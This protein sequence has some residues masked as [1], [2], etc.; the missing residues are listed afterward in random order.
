MTETGGSGL[1]GNSEGVP[2]AR[3]YPGHR[4]RSGPVPRIVELDA[5]R[6]LAACVVAIHHVFVVFHDEIRS[7]VSGF[8]YSL[9][10]VVQAQNQAAVLLFF[11]LSGYAIGLATRTQPPV[12]KADCLHY[13]SRRAQRLLPLY[14]ISLAWTASLGNVYGHSNSSFGL[15]TLF[16]NALF[17][18]TSE[19]AKGAWFSPYGLNGPYWSLS[20]EIFFYLL[21]PVALLVVHRGPIARWPT[22]CLL[23]LGTVA[24]CAGLALNITVP[25]PFSNFLTLWVVWLMG[26]ASVQ[27][28][29]KI[30]STV[31][32][33]APAAFFGI[34]HLVLAYLGRPSDTLSQVTQGTFI[35]ATFALV[36]VNPQRFS[37][38]PFQ[39]TR[40]AFT[41]VFRRIGDGSY[42]LYLLHYP[43]LLA[44]HALLDDPFGTVEW[45]LAG[46]AFLAFVVGFCPW[47]ERWSIRLTK[48]FGR[49]AR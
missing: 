23:V 45:W 4:E 30:T 34:G 32:V 22:T 39:W 24:S 13:L 36:A 43:L 38:P 8:A 12:S 20:Y 11:V 21:L 48:R 31:L 2:H 49:N 14:W 15:E 27:L 26:Y 25:S 10:D 29:A 7:V 47:L 1:P 6:G 19:F 46:I 9:L 40:R 18:Q 16:G 37:A 33:V 3:P 28:K 41:R 44:I 5:L 17:L 35:G 42:A